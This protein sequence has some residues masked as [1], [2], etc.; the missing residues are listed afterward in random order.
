LRYPAA[1]AL[2]VA[3]TGTGCGLDNEHDPI[4]PDDEVSGRGDL[5][6][7]DTIDE[8]A[9][10]GE[11]A[12]DLTGGAAATTGQFPATLHIGG[13]TAAKV[14]PRHILTAA[15]CVVNREGVMNADLR[16][17]ATMRV[18]NEIN[19]AGT[20][21]AIVV[22]RTSV[23]PS[24]TP[25]SWALKEPVPTDAAVIEVEGGLDN[26]PT[27]P[28]DLSALSP[29]TPVI[30]QGYGC[31]SGLQ[32]PGSTP[33]LK[34]FDTQLVDASVLSSSQIGPHPGEAP[35][36]SLRQSYLFTPARAIDPSGAS[37]CP[38]DSGGPMYTRRNGQLF[39]VGINAYYSFL[40]N[41]RQ[42]GIAAYNWL[43][44]LDDRTRHL[45]A[46]WLV[47]LGVSIRAISTGFA[48]DIGIGS[49]GSVWSIGAHPTGAGDFAVYRRTGEG[50]IPTEG[51][52]RHVAVAPDGTPWVVKENGQI[53]RRTGTTWQLL[54]GL[55][56]DIGVGADGSA[57]I[58]GANPVPGGFG[59]FRWTGSNWDQIDGGALRIAVT[60]GGSPWVVNDRAEIFSRGAN[61]W[62]QRAGVAYDIG[63]GANGAVWVIG[64]AAVPGGFGVFRWNGSGW[65]QID[66]GGVRIAVSPAGEPSIVND[67]G[68]VYAHTAQGWQRQ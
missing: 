12:A 41:N 47:N 44:R 45:V 22:R 43:T 20:H 64:G 42:A 61:G 17:G 66:G 35:V 57:W 60:P 38:G 33:R 39:V 1:W 9:Q 25:G 67:L 31:E 18:T 36:S 10:T 30:L 4:D 37:L 51:N 63:V 55:A 58:I 6:D 15:H 28:I 62:Q 19:P 13:C 14:G 52:A 24:W 68:E 40:S 29:G 27:A 34:F 7:P 5:G 53:F 50:W 23:H 3:I 26:I 16:P 65:S 59:V 49:N 21:R 2:C 48:K 54:P 46:Q 32:G 56:R 8:L 11:H